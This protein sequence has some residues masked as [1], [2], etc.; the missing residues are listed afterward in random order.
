VLIVDEPENQLIK[1]GKG[2]L[3]LL[4]SSGNELPLPVTVL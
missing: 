2:V 3:L 4:W 1:L